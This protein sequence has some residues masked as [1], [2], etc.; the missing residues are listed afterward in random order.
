MVNSSFSPTAKAA[1]TRNPIRG[2][3]GGLA[4]VLTLLSAGPAPLWATE[5][6]PV[7]AERVAAGLLPPLGERLPDE[8]RRDL[9]SDPAWRAGRYGGEM[10]MLIRGDRD[11][12]ELSLLGYARLVVW[13]PNYRLRPDIL[14]IL[15]VEDGR[16]FTLTLRQGH[17]WSD[18]AP[19]TAED[20][21][22]WWE[23]VANNPELSPGGP[24]RE[25]L[26]EGR[27][28]LFEVL[29]ATRVRYSWP[30]PNP[31]FLI[32]LAASSPL[33]IYRP[34]HYLKAFHARYRPR[35]ELE[36]L[37]AAAGLPDWAALHRRLDHP[38]LFDNPERPTLEPW[39]NKSAPPATRFLAERNPYFH[40]VDEAGR[41]LPYIDRVVL[42]GTPAQLI[43]FK[44]SAGESDLQA[45]GLTF[46]EAALLKQAEAER[47][48]AL[49]LWPVGR[50]SQIA[51]YPNLNA[52]DPVWREVLRD[53]RVRRALSL[54]IDREEINQAI[55]RGLGL[56]GAN[57][58]LPQSPL[59]KPSYRE[60][61]SD[62]DPAEANRLLDEAG[63]EPGPDGLRRLPD[64]RPFAVVVET[65]EVDPSE[66]DILQLIAGTWRELGVEL[67]TRSSGRQAFRQRVRSG[68]TVMSTFY[69]LANALATANSDPAELAPTDERQNNWPL[70]GLHW[71]SGGRKGQAPDWPP[72][73]RL[74][75]LYRA[76]ANAS[77]EAGRRAAWEAMLELHA[78][79]V[80]TIGLV[81][82]VLQP[83]VTAPALQNL[84]K[85]AFY[86]YEP[87][88]YLGLHR[89]DTFWFEEARQ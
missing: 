1:A 25:M 59:Y 85:R 48:I 62:F 50:G 84:P 57:T 70:W 43:P 38:F 56:P 51:L 26:V 53:R 78:E 65:G 17:R 77:D 47:R 5:E 71:E 41:Q 32:A 24:P 46:A 23:E 13:G 11:P 18:G 76:W 88:A 64:G 3:R 89:P 40:R 58:L 79:E 74:L 10:R 49:R 81:A 14:E 37:A 30:A 34:A 15:E 39:V 35:A 8:P 20:F 9:P 27:P 45:R 75:A 31:R 29:D 68:E 69:G 52:A 4:L 42:I 82:G 44:S 33:Y 80:L 36:A 87:G 73:E 12:R 21:R 28:P 72:A 86:L 7:L 54:G 16:R 66:S 2:L 61:W 22:Y 19:F 60:A 63:L 6:P 55:Y 83:I 67:L